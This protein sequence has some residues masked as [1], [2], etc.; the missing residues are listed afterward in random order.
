[1]VCGDEV[2]H[3]KPAPDTFQAAAKL[4]GNPAPEE[5]LVLEDSPAGA[6]V[7]VAYMGV[8]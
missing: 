7:G 6:L 8:C 2:P 4:L 5:C 3:G 1:M